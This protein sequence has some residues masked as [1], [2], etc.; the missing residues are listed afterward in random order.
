[1]STRPR[2]GLVA[3]G[4]TPRPDLEVE[5]RNLCDAD[6][7]TVGALDSLDLG[8]IHALNDPGG[9]Y[10]LHT[11]LRDGSVVDIPIDDMAPLVG[12][13]VKRLQVSSDLVVV[14]CAGRFPELVCDVPLI[15]PGK[16]TL[17][18]AQALSTTRRVGV[19]VPN[20]GQVDEARED[21]ERT[22][23]RPRVTFA[24]P[25]EPSEIDRA[26]RELSDDSLDFIVVECMGHGREFQARIAGA[27]GHRTL[28]AQTLTARVASEVL[29]GITWQHPMA[30]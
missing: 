7:T 12:A 2:L 14:L 17:A 9:H 19:I 8:R 29:Q 13:Q 20:Q 16:L 15:Y 24:S 21:Y 27:S 3:L 4:H 23:F 1:L 30:T 22:G 26:G 28:L 18:M 5:F 10:P 6:L 25:F 11:R